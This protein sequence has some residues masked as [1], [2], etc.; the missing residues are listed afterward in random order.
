MKVPQMLYY[1]KPDTAPSPTG[2]EGSL[3]RALAMDQ[4]VLETAVKETISAF[5]HDQSGDNQRPGE[6]PSQAPGQQ[7][8]G[9]SRHGE[10]G[11]SRWDSGERL[12]PSGIQEKFFRGS[13]Q[14]VPLPSISIKDPF[15]SNLALSRGPECWTLSVQSRIR[16]EETYRMIL[17]FLFCSFLMLISILCSLSLS[18]KL[19]PC[20]F[21]IINQLTL[22]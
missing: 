14:Q 12:H 6:V 3:L 19:I 15:H 2:D 10:H 11:E 22:Y 5:S 16:D 4:N 20:Y 8:C 17:S 13:K 7:R 18:L 9:E 1:G 21:S